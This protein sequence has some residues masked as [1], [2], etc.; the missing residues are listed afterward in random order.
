MVLPHPL[1]HKKNQL[2][3]CIVIS[4]VFNPI[5]QAKNQ[6]DS[7]IKEYAKQSFFKFSDSFRSFLVVNTG[8]N[9]TGSL[10][11]LLMDIS[12]LVDEAYITSS[13]AI[14]CFY[15]ILPCKELHE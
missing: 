5:V 14:S 2:F 10:I 8:D 6:Q 9:L 13:F 11:V 15:F 12:Q 3:L 7:E 1:L 4:I